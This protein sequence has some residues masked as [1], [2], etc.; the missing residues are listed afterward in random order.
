MKKICLILFIIFCS[1]F[2]SKA[3][4]NQQ[5]EVYR[6]E[7]ISVTPGK[8]SISESVP[9]P[10]LIPKSEMEKMPLIDNDI[11]RSAHSLPGVVADDFSA[12]FSLRGGDRDE[13]L[14]RLDGME[15]YDPYH[16]QDFGGAMSAIDMGMVRSA[17]LLTGGFPAEYGNVMSGV[18][19]IQSGSANRGRISGNVGIDVLN[20]HAIL[21]GP[22]GNTSW[23]LAARRGYID[24]LMG[25]IESE[26][27]FSPSFYDIYSKLGYDLTTKDKVSGHILYADDSNEIDQIG[28]DNDVNS[29]YWNGMF[30]AKWQHLFNNNLFWD[31]YLFYGYAGREKYE[32]IDGFDKRSL[33]YFGVKEDL[34]YYTDK[35]TAKAGWRLQ[36]S[37]AEYDYFNKD[38]RMTTEVD[39]N[40]SGW[41]F[42]GY[43]QDEIKPVKW[44]G[45]NFGLRYMYQSDGGYSSLMPRLALA[46]IP[47]KGLTIRGAWGMYNQPV[48]VTNLPV[49]EGIGESNP[50]EK[51]THYVMAAE[52]SPAPNMLFKVEAY[53]KDFDN[54][55]GRLI[56]HGR[57]EQMFI[58]PDSGSSRGL[59]LFAK[60]SMTSRFTWGIAYALSKAQVET[61][62][63]TVPRNT[64]R[65]HTL[66]LYLDYAVW[67]DGWLNIIWRYHS[68]EP[69]TKTWYVKLLSESG[70]SYVWEKK[71]GPI[72]DSRYPAYHSLD[73]RLTKNFRFRNFEMI[74]Y[75][76]MMNL[77][78]HKNIHEYSWEEMQD[79][80]GN[81]YYKR[82]IEHF[83]P[84]LP[85]IGVSAQ[86]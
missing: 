5:D 82:V 58:S 59:E 51:A 65:R 86:F 62:S 12:R 74:L 85:T 68:G 49:E 31:T 81:I 69:Y 78:N 29:D 75:F 77:Y 72:N 25:L 76:Q 70:E 64:D 50:P 45:A 41:N 17:D 83:L 3:D 27:K 8:Y 10:Y 37:K 46:V 14:I 56:D 2:I 22:L 57:K 6:L 15:L 38:D 44:L 54:L 61:D 80:D 20:T 52:Y 47:Q 33:L 11:Y 55:V 19:D 34:I 67:N 32:G 71:Y 21:T 40:P 84:V 30:W 63:G 79:E 1:A 35:N 43:L 42:S 18:F 66:N 4:E 39:S 73:V 24:L 28:E 26:E 60:H 36:S 23:L 9:S 7:E 16:L 13:V 53:Y 48:R